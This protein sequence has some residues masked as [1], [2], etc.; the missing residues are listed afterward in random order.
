[1]V[2][3][4]EGDDKFH[5]NAAHRFAGALLVPAEILWP[6]VDRHRSSIGGGELFALKQL[7]RAS[8]QAI[9]YRCGN[10]GIFPPS[11]AQSCSRSF[12]AW[13]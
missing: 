8:V 7:F 10:L 1:M 4:A 13:L 2:M 3:E 5:E 6:N 11:L 9:V 12:P